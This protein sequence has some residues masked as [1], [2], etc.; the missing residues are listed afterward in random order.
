MTK[1]INTITQISV[2]TES[3]NP[4]FGECTRI[5]LEDECG[6]MFFVLEQ[7][8][9]SPEGINQIRISVEEWPAIT[10]AMLTLRDQ[11]LVN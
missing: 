4:V 1:Y 2:G 7:D 6:G 5:R 10:R 8:G 11:P 3:D 9:L